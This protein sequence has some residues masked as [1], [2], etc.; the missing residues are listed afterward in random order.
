MLDDRDLAARVS[1]AEYGYKESLKALE[2][3]DQNRHLADVTFGRYRNLF[4][5]KV[6]SGQEMD[7]VETQK[8][9]ADL[10]YERTREATNR[11]RAQL[12]E[13]RITREF[14]RIVAPH[15][16]LITGKKTDQGSLAAPGSPLLVLEDTSR[17]RVEAPV[18][19]RMA[20]RQGRHAGRCN[21]T[22]R[23][24]E[25]YRKRR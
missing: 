20:P 22:L 18:D 24:E 17:Y 1:A 19:Q 11:V 3:A 23:R 13:A 6:I 16:G 15:D 8:R 14:T 4:K 9:V 12:E 21:A 10:G 5:D 25:S 7:Q 2:E